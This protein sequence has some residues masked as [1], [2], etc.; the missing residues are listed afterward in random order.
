MKLGKHVYPEIGT[1]D[2]SALTGIARTNIAGGLGGTN[3]TLVMQ[4]L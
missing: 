1:K 2:Q 3:A 4:K